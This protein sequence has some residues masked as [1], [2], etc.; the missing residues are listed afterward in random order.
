M[1]AAL[2][3]NALSAMSR[4]GSTDTLGVALK[5]SVT[6]VG[7]TSRGSPSVG[8]SEVAVGGVVARIAAVH[9]RLAQ[10]V[11]RADD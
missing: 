7:T 11:G 3:S 9:D 2:R 8:C 6:L 10:V 4:R 1:G 5:E